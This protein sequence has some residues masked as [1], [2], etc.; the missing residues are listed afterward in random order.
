MHYFMKGFHE[1]NLRKHCNIPTL[2]G[3][4]CWGANENIPFSSAPF[5]KFWIIFVMWIGVDFLSPGKIYIHF[6]VSNRVNE[7]EGTLCFS[8]CVKP[9]EKMIFFQGD[10]K[11][12]F[13]FFSKVFAFVILIL[14][15]GGSIQT[16][17]RLGNT[18]VVK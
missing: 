6:Y 12:N 15:T 14:T 7:E 17:W 2:H 5:S 13:S 10:S 4:A 16:L 1:E 18:E 8:M 3:N 11:A 9:C